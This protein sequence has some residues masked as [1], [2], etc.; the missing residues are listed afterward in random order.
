MKNFL[1]LSYR[2]ILKQKISSIINIIGLAI[3][4]AGFI[5]IG[6]YVYDEM[7][8]DKFHENKS[9]IF[10]LTGHMV[11]DKDPFVCFPAPLYTRLGDEH[12][13]IE[14]IVRIFSFPGDYIFY[15][16][17]AFQENGIIF[18]DPAF[19][20][21]F[22]FELEKGS[23][24]SFSENPSSMILSKTAALKYFGDD[25]PI[26][27]GLKYNGQ[28]FV[29]A[30][31]IKDIP[32]NSF[33][34]FDVLI[35][36]DAFSIIHSFMAS[37][38]QAWSS[39][40]F[41]LMK[42]DFDPQPLVDRFLPF[43]LPESGENPMGLELKLQNLQ[44]IYLGPKYTFDIIPGTRGNMQAFRIFSVSA[45]FILLLAC[46]N[47]I[48]LVTAKSSL[49]AREVGIRKVL[50]ADR[51]QLVVYFL[52]ESLL[53][54][55]IAM[56]LGLFMVEVS[57]PYFSQ[58]AGKDISLL[59]IPI[60][61][62]LFYLLLL[63]LVVSFFSGIH[64]AFI[65][66]SYN[67]VIVLKGS[68]L[69][70]SQQLKGNFLPKLRLRQL[71]IV[72]QFAMSIALVSASIIL[73][74]QILYSQA[75]AGFEKDSLLVIQNYAHPNMTKAFLEFRNQM[76]QHPYISNVS[77]AA[78]LPTNHMGN[79]GSLRQPQQTREDAVKTLLAPVDF[80]FFQTLGA[81]LLWGRWFEKD[82]ASD[83]L[84]AVILNQAAARALGL[85]NEP[86]IW[87]TGFF[88]G[89][90]RRVVGIVEDIRFES[91]HNLVKPTA[92]FVTY[93][94]T[95]Y[96][97]GAFQL[98]V[99]YNNIKNEELVKAAKTSWHNS[100]GPN[101]IF[102]YYFMDQRYDN[103]YYEE[104][105]ISSVSRVFT[106]L[107]I[108]IALLGLTGTT[109]YILEARKK[110]LGV[111]RVLGASQ[112]RMAYMISREFG[113]LVLLSIMIAVPV[114]YHFMSGW[115]DTFVY[116]IGLGPEAFIISGLGA[117]LL[118]LAIVN[119]ILGMQSRENPVNALKYE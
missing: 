95:Y 39:Q 32:R 5:I 53:I 12:P 65:L 119:F 51:K 92:F 7:K 78:Y 71:L 9:N 94:P 49:R 52:L 72:L 36:F 67:P 21:V 100:A 31:I 35:N 70:I 11:G 50:G 96:P 20:D 91:S 58:I 33:M 117:L 107:A 13:E 59:H 118:A 56:L 63:L 24:Q 109:I 102:E 45:V 1:L 46:F 106:F 43:F 54:C 112:F 113:L 60:L 110:E 34:Q 93:I 101:S 25:D 77:S 116:R 16:G 68:A 69:Y 105:Q 75:N 23:L 74:K 80:D 44:Q 38:W 62:L 41:F 114:A 104:N 89:R 19:F 10:R 86:D 37:S 28:D 76:L 6:L 3:G 47:Y 99:R 26:G 81:R 55:S 111:R 4:F 108:I 17:E 2:N 98:M 85:E 115:L 64:P 48:N 84:D 87:L 90:N 42:D 79:I 22:S 82:R 18:A 15:E 27:K 103:L 88:D 83:S 14:K 73:Y 61:Q 8:F 57:L 66:S 97:S 29:V 30:G 40:F